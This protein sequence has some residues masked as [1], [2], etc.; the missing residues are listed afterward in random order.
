MPERIF[1]Q[2]PELPQ[3]AQRASAIL[4]NCEPFPGGNYRVQYY[5]LWKEAVRRLMR[6]EATDLHP[7]HGKPTVFRTDISTNDLP[8]I[9]DQDQ[10]VALRVMKN[11]LNRLKSVSMGY[12]KIKLH[13]YAPAELRNN[14][15][16]PTGG[17]ELYDITKEEFRDAEGRY[18]MLDQRIVFS[19]DDLIGG[20]VR[21][22][23]DAV[24]TVELLTH[25]EAHSDLMQRA[26]GLLDIVERA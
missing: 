9:L 3:L 22:R 21:S 7:I 23:A 4:E 16:V 15:L 26:S 20:Y 8:E 1:S 24:N 13:G 17:V 5:P 12:S 10:D 14:Q 18:L 25:N 19:E 6:R 2:F 11:G